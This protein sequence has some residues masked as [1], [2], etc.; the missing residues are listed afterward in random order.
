MIKAGIIGLGKM[1]I[2]HYA[3]TNAHPNVDLAAVCD[4]LGFVVGAISKY[5]GVRTYKDYRKMIDECDMDCVIIATPSSY[6]ADMIRHALKNHLHVFVEKPFCLSID[7]GK[8]MVELAKEKGVANQVGY[9]NRFIGAFQKVRELL[10]DHAIGQVYHFTAEAYGPVILKPKGLTWRTKRSE[11]GG[12]LHDYASHVVNLVSYLIGQPDNVAGTVFKTIFSRDVEDA[13]YSTLLYN[14]GKSG[15]LAVNWSD[16]T[17]RKMSTM[18]T[19]YGS[20]GKIFSDR[21]ECRVHLKHNTG[22]L[23]KGWNIFYTTELTEPVWYYLRGEE[24]STQLD[25]FF[26][27]VENK[28]TENVNSFESALQTDIVINLLT[29]NA[30]KRKLN[31]G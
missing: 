14:S 2:S 4:S 12:C 29:S 26:K 25:Y 13:V 27:C 21:Q 7:D 18:I 15:Q 16:E 20:E 24:Y 11:G 17:Y 6:H 8:E 9:H 30:E 1:G 28:R 10:T 22:R 23:E 19:V 5:T 31:I 3:I